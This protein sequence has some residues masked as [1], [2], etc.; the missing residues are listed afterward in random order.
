MRAPALIIGTDLTHIPQ[1][2]LSTEMFRPK[3]IT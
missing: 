2:D 3:E 1:G